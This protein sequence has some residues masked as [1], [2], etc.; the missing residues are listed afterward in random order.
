MLLSY[1]KGANKK[2]DIT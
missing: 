2:I 1:N